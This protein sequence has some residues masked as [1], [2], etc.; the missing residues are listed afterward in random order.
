MPRLRL[1][2]TRWLALGVGL[3]FSAG[4]Y[5][6]VAQAP[7]TCAL[8]GC[9]VAFRTTRSWPIA[10][11]GHVEPNV[12]LRFPNGIAMRL[13]AGYSSILN[14]RDDRCT[15]TLAGGCPSSLGERRGY[16][17]FALGYAF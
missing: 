5:E 17:G 14:G 12:E 13:F 8:V 2:I 6:Y 11:W 7:E 1:P 15:S 3:P 16:G 10:F 9:G 4:P